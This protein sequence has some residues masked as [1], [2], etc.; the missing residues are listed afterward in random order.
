LNQV[1]R[2]RKLFDWILGISLLVLG[3]VGLVLPVLQGVLLILAGLAVL[4]SH[5]ALARRIQEALKSGI[6]RIRDRRARPDD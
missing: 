4:S 3:L 2:A 5:S 6:R 1:S